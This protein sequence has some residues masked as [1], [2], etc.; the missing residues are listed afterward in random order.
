MRPLLF[1]LGLAIAAGAEAHTAL[2]A[3]LLQGAV[4]VALIYIATW[5]TT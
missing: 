3:L 1:T 2:P 4:G 5:R